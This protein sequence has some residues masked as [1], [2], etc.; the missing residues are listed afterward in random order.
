MAYTVA[1]DVHVAPLTASATEP[2]ETALGGRGLDVRAPA[3]RP[4]VAVN[5]VCSLDG[6]T[7]VDGRAGGL[8]SD[9]DKAVFTHL[10]TAVDAVL[11]GAGTVRAE[12]Y[13]P[14]VPDSTLQDHRL[15][16]Q[17]AA[18]P[19]AVIVSGSLAL[20]RDLPLLQDAGSHVVVLTSQ[21]QRT[22]GTVPAQVDYMRGPGPTLE[23]RP[24]LE[25]LRTNYAVRSIL[26][27]GGPTLNAALLRE[28]LVDCLFLTLAPTLA[29]GPLPLTIV[30][31]PAFDPRPRARFVRA[32]TAEDNLFLEYH[33]EYQPEGS[34]S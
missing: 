2:V 34:R 6:R 15:A 31:G 8:S 23:L 28:S 27:E 5:M 11:I 10:R 22:I 14:M 20:P 7:T 12:R 33:L 24:F 13:G 19:L 21:T 3:D 17:R 18:Q 30:D 32:L 9:S 25:R 29:G 16:A 4:Y 1:L 26:C